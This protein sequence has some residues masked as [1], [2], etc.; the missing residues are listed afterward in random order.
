MARL[1]ERFATQFGTTSCEELT[2]SYPVS[3]FSSK[4]RIKRCM[5]IIAFV[6]RETS[7]LLSDPDDN[8]SDEE[9]RS[10]FSLRESGNNK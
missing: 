4:G 1:V 9:R 2:K 6:T 8:F 10:Y 5:D 7:R 3:E